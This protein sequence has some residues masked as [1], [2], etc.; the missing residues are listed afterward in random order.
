MGRGRGSGCDARGGGGEAGG[1]GRGAQEKGHHSSGRSPR[2]EAP[3]REARRPWPVDTKALMER[4]S[5]LVRS[6]SG[7]L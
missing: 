6:S 7:A 4:P 2:T 3:N 5:S 1:P